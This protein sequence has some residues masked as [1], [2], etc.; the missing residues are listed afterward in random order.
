M[1]IYRVVVILSISTNLVAFF[2]LIVGH[3]SYMSTWQHYF[4]IISSMI[5]TTPN[6]LDDAIR[7]KT[8]MMLAYIQTDNERH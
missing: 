6:L 2:I 5:P 3:T 1:V 8:K 4:C 7:A